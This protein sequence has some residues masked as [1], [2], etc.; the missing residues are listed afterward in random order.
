MPVAAVDGGAKQFVETPRLL[1]GIRDEVNVGLQRIQFGEMFEQQRDG[2]VE[3]RL[4]LAADVDGF[5]PARRQDGNREAGE[6]DPAPRGNPPTARAARLS[7][8]TRFVILQ[9]QHCIV[10]Q[11]NRKRVPV[12]RPASSSRKSDVT[13]TDR[14]K[15]TDRS[16]VD[17]VEFAY[18]F[19]DIPEKLGCAADY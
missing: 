8:R 14:F 16:L 19:D 18:R 1:F 7:D 13:K 11:E 17:G 12:L 5:G 3:G 6:Q 10:C 9:K 15:L 2:S 4:L